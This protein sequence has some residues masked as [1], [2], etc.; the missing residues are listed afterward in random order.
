MRNGRRRPNRP[1][2]FRQRSAERFHGR[3]DGLPATRKREASVVRRFSFG[4]SRAGVSS[5]CG[6]GSGNP[7]EPLTVE[8][9]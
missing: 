5:R 6:V 7:L 1:D 2:V 9:N 4:Q 3:G 8:R